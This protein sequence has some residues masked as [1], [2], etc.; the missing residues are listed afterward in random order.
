MKR[1]PFL[2]ALSGLGLL[3]AACA[4][5]EPSGQ[6]LYQ[7]HCAACHGVSGQGDGPVASQLQRPPT[8]LTGIAR[9]AGGGFDESAVARVIS[10]EQS[11][12][13]HGT[14]EMPVWGRVFAEELR[15]ERFSAGL[16]QSEV[17]ALTLHLRSI[18]A[19]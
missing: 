6:A 10:G 9:R 14:R 18:Q 19:E 4:G 11:V 2:A 17:A 5:G 12:P 16:V 15:G 13:E 8:D 7:R 1:G 3:A